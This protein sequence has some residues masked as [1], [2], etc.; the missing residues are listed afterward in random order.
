MVISDQ[1]MSSEFQMKE[2]HINILFLCEL[3]Q[4]GYTRAILNTSETEQ[5]WFL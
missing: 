2:D 1:T 5:T 3:H 4:L